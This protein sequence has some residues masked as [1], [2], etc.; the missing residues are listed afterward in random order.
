[1]DKFDLLQEM[2][3]FQEQR[4]QLE[5]MSVPMMVQGKILFGALEKNAETKELALLAGS[6][7][8]HLEYELQDRS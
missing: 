8:R 5:E 6:Y 7:R 3:R 2:L 4:S 1:M